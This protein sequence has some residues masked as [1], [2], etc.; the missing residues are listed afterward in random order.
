MGRKREEAASAASC[1]WIGSSAKGL[2]PRG[3]PA[4]T[5]VRVKARHRA[6]RNPRLR[7]RAESC[8]PRRRRPV[9]SGAGG[10]RRNRAIGNP[11]PRTGAKVSATRADGDR[12][13]RAP[14]EESTTR[15]ERNRGLR[16]LAEDG[17]T[18]ISRTSTSVRAKTGALGRRRRRVQ[19]RAERNPCPRTGAEG[20]ANPCGRNLAPSGARENRHIALAETSAFGRWRKPMQRA[21]GNPSPRTKAEESASHRRK[22]GLSGP[23]GTRRNRAEENRRPRTLAGYRANPC[24]R[25]PGSSDLGTNRRNRADGNPRSRAWAEGCA[26]VLEKMMHPSGNGAAPSGTAERTDDPRRERPGPSGTGRKHRTLRLETP[27]F[28]RERKTAPPE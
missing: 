17:A 28:G 23:G 6:G 5:S 20:R 9:L 26:T 8:A 21:I 2:R 27:V 7:A 25:D 24:W 19:P 16:A 13:L 12:C 15:V 11:C 14:E 4:R 1:G 3:Q 10:N 22:P 18:R